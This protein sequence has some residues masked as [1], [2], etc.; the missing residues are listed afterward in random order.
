MIKFLIVVVFDLIA[1]A[2]TGLVGM[3]CWNW[4]VPAYVASAPPMTFAIAFG[5]VIMCGVFIPS[6]RTYDIKD[7]E[8]D[9]VMILTNALLTQTINGIANPIVLLVF[10]WFAHS[11]LF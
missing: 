10:A 1:F 3:I 11:L 8:G 9:D 5:L 2:V 7:L 4:F 6:S